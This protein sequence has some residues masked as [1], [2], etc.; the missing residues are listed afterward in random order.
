MKN[1]YLSLMLQMLKLFKPFMVD[2]FSARACFYIKQNQ[3]DKG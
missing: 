2:L 3:A 1:T